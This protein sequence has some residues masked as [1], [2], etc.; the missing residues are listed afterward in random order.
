MGLPGWKAS[1]GRSY[2][3]HL[4]DKETKA[5]LMFILFHKRVCF[6][7]CDKKNHGWREGRR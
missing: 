2:C 4:S 7:Q 5:A 3:Y 6:W 1:T